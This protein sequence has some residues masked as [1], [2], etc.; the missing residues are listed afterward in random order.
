MRH[1]K[2]ACP[3]PTDAGLGKSLEDFVTDLVNS[4]RYR[5]RN[6]VLREGVRLLK[7]R[8]KSLDDLDSALAAGLADATG[9]RLKPAKTVL[10]RLEKKY[11][12]GAAL[13]GK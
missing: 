5:T 11:R 6:E 4:G 9:G 3:M 7:A 8:E 1:R 10:D 2:R 12:A 13:A